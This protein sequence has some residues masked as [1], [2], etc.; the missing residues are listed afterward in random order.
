MEKQR[1][2]AVSCSETDRDEKVI[3]TPCRMEVA[4]L[5]LS[6]ASATREVNRIIIEKMKTL[7]NLYDE[8]L[9]Q[10]QEELSQCTRELAFE[11]D[12]KTQEI[13]RYSIARFQEI[14]KTYEANKVPEMLI[15]N[16]EDGT[17]CRVTAKDDYIGWLC[18]FEIT[19]MEV[20]D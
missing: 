9:S 19:P 11:D 5:F 2:Y 3:D 13:L 1:I 17:I 15:E 8:L 16:S 7:S 6:I 10:I 20:K 14:Q 18:V 12:P 4:G